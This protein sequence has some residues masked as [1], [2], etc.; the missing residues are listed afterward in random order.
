MKRMWCF[1]EKQQFLTYQEPCFSAN[2]CVERS[3]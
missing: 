2:F 1:G 3:R